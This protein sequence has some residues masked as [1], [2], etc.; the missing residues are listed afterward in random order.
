MH[1]TGASCAQC[2]QPIPSSG[3]HRSCIGV[4]GPVAPD[5]AG[6]SASIRR[7]APGDSGRDARDDKPRL[8]SSAR[9]EIANRH[10]GNA[11]GRLSGISQLGRLPFASKV[12]AFLDPLNAGVYDNRLN[13]FLEK[14]SLG[15]IL[16]GGGGAWPSK[17][18]YMVNP[19]VSRPA[20]QQFYQR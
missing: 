14:D 10:W 1:I 12:I 7:I 15:R 20:A 8:G 9:P 3:A 4:L 19:R 11:I 2:S 6:S 13:Y 5:T 17:G 18:G 16:M